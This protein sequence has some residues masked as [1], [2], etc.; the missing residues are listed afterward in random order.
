MAETFAL[1]LAE[2][3]KKAGARADEAVTLIVTRLAMK[4]DK[5]SP[6]GNPKY[7]KRPPPAGYVGGRF[8]GNWQ[9][10]VDTQPTGTLERIAPNGSIEIELAKIPEEAAGHVY[11]L[12]NN[13]PYA[14]RLEDGWSRRQSAPHA[15]VGLSMA[16]AQDVVNDAVAAAV[17][18]IP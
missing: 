10:G 12:V 8:R 7:W 18:K 5:R 2:F 4:I 1:Q 6:V 17:A 9:I 3:V 11:W 14:Q 16:E 13:L 15:M